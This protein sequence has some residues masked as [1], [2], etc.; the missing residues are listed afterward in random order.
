MALTK[1]GLD[2]EDI[3]TD[4]GTIYIRVYAKENRDKVD[5]V[6]IGINCTNSA[7]FYGSN[8][9]NTKVLTAS[10]HYGYYSANKVEPDAK[11]TPLGNTDYR[12]SSELESINYTV[13]MGDDGY[14]MAKYRSD[15]ED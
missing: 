13:K 9:G 3:E 14:Y 15:P 2:C 8:Y 4:G 12:D 11:V 10:S 6:A 5:T 1:Y 7:K